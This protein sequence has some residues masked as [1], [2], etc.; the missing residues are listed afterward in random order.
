MEHSEFPE[1]GRD[2]ARGMIK[3]TVIGVS[4]GSYMEERSA[5]HAAAAWVLECQETGA[6]CWGTL[7]VP[8][9]STD[10]N[11][12]RAEPFGILAMRTAIDLLQ[13]RW[14]IEAG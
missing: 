5:Q 8:G 7:P 11:P 10:I 13:E 9:E 6:T 3:G 4:D 2:V 1:E 12:Y 14:Q